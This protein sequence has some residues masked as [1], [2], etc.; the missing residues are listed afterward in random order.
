MMKYF[1][2]AGLALAFV[3]ALAACASIPNPFTKPTLAA[4]EAS[5]GAALS[6]AVGYRD[7]CAKRLIP[8]DCRTIVPKVQSYGAQAQ[9]AV[10]VARRFVKNNPTIDATAVL[11]TAQDAVNALKANTPTT[12]VK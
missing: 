6:V 12:G 2:N 3:T 9:S 1:R 8:P 11:T 4:V 10:L 5:Y 7:A